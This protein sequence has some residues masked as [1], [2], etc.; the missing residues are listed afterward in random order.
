MKHKST[1]TPRQEFLLGVK[2]QKFKVWTLRIGI[3]ALLFAF[4]ELFTTV[5]IMDSF[6]TSS[7]S[8]IIKTSFYLFHSGE[9]WKHLFVTTNECLIALILS[10]VIGFVFAVLLW[11][12]TTARKVGEPYLVVL[13]AL[14]KI[15]LGP[16]IIIWFG[17]NEKSIVAMGFLICIV[18][19]II[20]FLG[21]FISVDED[22]IFLLRSMGANKFQILIKL[23]IP[24][25]VPSIIDT[26]KIVVG[27]SWVGVIMGEYLVSGAG[28]GYLI[29]YGGQV[30]K[31]D[32]VMASTAVLCILATI[33]YAVVAFVGKLLR[34]YCV[35]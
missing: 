9:I 14:P 34:R 2:K 10:L 7:P 18:V 1:L 28:L 20:N 25:S 16:I 35:S 5:G 3:L 27:L 23:V 17:A 32:L 29:I 31:I 4:W 33:M 12:N 30:F 13:N 11:W 26:V 19:T 15:A 24:H 22:K 21:A 6:F 8:R